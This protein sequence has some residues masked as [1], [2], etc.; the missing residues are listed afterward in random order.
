MPSITNIPHK[1]LSFNK[2]KIKISTIL[3]SESEQF[4][5]LTLENDENIEIF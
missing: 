4:K 2:K 1:K 5:L 3:V